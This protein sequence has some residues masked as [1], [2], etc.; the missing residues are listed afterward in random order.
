MHQNLQ[1]KVA[2]CMESCKHFTQANPCFSNSRPRRL[3]Q[4]QTGIF[5][6]SRH[7]YKYVQSI[8]IIDAKFV[9]TG[10]YEQA[11]QAESQVLS[12]VM[13]M[14]SN[15]SSQ[16]LIFNTTSFEIDPLFF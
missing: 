5:V 13:N 9:A 15:P 3:G 6:H 10:Y 7:R 8:I 14:L 11:T 1:L 2:Y 12:L 16:N 4:I